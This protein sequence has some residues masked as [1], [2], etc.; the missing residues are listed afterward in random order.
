MPRARYAVPAYHRHPRPE[1]PNGAEVAHLALLAVDTVE[2]LPPALT[3]SVADL[4]ELDAVL[5]SSLGT[6]TTKLTTLLE[7]IQDP[8]VAP[9]DRLELLREVADEASGF[10]M[11][12]EDKIRVATGTCETVHQHAGQLDLIAGMLTAL[13]PP[14]L[15]EQVPAS[16][17]PAGYPHLFPSYNSATGSSHKTRADLFPLGAGSVSRGAAD[18]YNSAVQ[19]VQAYQRDIGPYAPRPRRDP[20][21]TVKKRESRALDRTSS[22]DPSYQPGR[23]QQPAVA[24]GAAAS[25]PAVPRNR[26]ASQSAHATADE[27]GAQEATAPKRPRPRMAE[28]DGGDYNGDGG[29]GNGEGSRAG[30]LEP[31]AR[32]AKRQRNSATASATGTPAASAGAQSPVLNRNG[33]GRRRAKSVAPLSTLLT[34]RRGDSPGPTKRARNTNADT[35]YGE[36]GEAIE[37]DEPAMDVDPTLGD[38]KVEEAGADAAAAAP[39]D[40]TA[41]A[42]PAASD[43]PPAAAEDEQTYCICNRVSFG[44][45]IGCDDEDCKTE[46]VRRR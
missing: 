25:S 45:M 23:T 1:A 4:K 32:P 37:E 24:A 29:E 10:K 46:W 21:T 16:S 13:M 26:P 11:G 38:I 8:S 28:A 15:L 6:I 17:T 12:G 2:S 42:K 7:M 20:S 27:G 33:N 9:R 43:E 34:R 31:G 3:R 22:Q 40:A 18:K 35:A 44:E 14:H 30:S 41:A 5:T 39:T 36:D 19:A